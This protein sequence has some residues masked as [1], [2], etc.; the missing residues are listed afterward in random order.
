MSVLDG[1]QPRGV[2]DADWAAVCPAVT[3]LLAEVDEP[4]GRRARYPLVALALYARQAGHEVTPQLLLEESLIALWA[5]TLTNTRTAGSYRSALRQL[6]DAHQPARRALRQPLTRTRGCPPP[7]THRQVEQMLAHAGALSTEARRIDAA[8]LVLTG[9][10][11]GLD[12]RDLFGLSGAAVSRRADGLVVADVVGSRR[13]R[14]VAVLERYSDRLAEVAARSEALEPGRWLV[15]SS[16]QAHGVTERARL[17]FD[18]WGDE[19]VTARRLRITWLATHLTAGTGLPVLLA[20][21]GTSSLRVLEEV[22]DHLAGALTSDGGNDAE[23]LA[24]AAGA[25]R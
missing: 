4:L 10:G 2:S 24:A 1:Y 21:A 22:A 7:Y 8:A 15:G 12:G 3:V 16:P 5:A 25:L 11:A 17:L 19:P 20:Q 13:P 18:G 6:A 9:A 23:M 14:T